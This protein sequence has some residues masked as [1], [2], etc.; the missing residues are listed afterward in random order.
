M[1]HFDLSSSFGSNVPA[2]QPLDRV[3]L[4]RIRRG[5][6]AVQAPVDLEQL[7]YLHPILGG[8]LRSQILPVGRGFSPKSPNLPAPTPNLVRRLVL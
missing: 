7:P 4:L 1:P 8:L 2:L 5:R 3:S 6:H